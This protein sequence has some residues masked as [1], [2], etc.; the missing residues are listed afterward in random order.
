MTSFLI[1]RAI[2]C[3]QMFSIGREIIAET[4]HWLNW[5]SKIM[6]IAKKQVS[7]LKCS[8]RLLIKMKRPRMWE[9]IGTMCRLICSSNKKRSK[10]IW[11]WVIQILCRLL[12]FLVLKPAKVRD[13]NQWSF[14]IVATDS[15]I[16]EITPLLSSRMNS[17]PIFLGVQDMISISWEEEVVD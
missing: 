17:Q 5:G 11:R 2:I 4:A 6:I 8:N 3:H 12:K 10:I 14:W 15:T 1:S 16:L 13:V 7:L 9:T